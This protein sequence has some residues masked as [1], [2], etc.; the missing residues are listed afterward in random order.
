MAYNV[1]YNVV[2]C[3]CKHGLLFLFRRCWLVWSALGISVVALA[4]WA[5][6]TKTGFVPH[7]DMGML[8]LN[9]TASPGNTLAQTRKAAQQVDSILTSPPEVEY[10]GSATAS[11]QDR[12]Y[13]TDPYSSGSTIGTSAS[14]RD[15]P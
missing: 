1:S 14:A 3:K 11:W 13:L 15:I 6:T 2:L 4:F 9:I 8:Y 10:F 5:R 12:A 7:E